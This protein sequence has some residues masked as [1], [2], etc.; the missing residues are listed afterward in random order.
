MRGIEKTNNNEM[1]GEAPSA[2]AW[3]Y[4]NGRNSYSSLG[5]V[6]SL[7][8]PAMSCVC[9]NQEVLLFISFF[10][11]ENGEE[12]LIEEMEETVKPACSVLRQPLGA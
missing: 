9:M 1:A 3:F 7:A 11:V 4:S 10:L 8:P 6:T 12:N 5:I 2:T